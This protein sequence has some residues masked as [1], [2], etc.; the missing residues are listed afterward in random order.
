MPLGAR[1]TGQLV[2]CLP[3]LPD[4]AVKLRHKLV[5]V[6]V[7]AVVQAVDVA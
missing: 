2:Y 3:R 1:M 4:C 7:E 5:D 6:V